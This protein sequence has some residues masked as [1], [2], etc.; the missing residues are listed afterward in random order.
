MYKLKSGNTSILDL[1]FN[2]YSAPFGSFN[3][4]DAPLTE[5]TKD[6]LA[7]YN[8]SFDKEQ[9]WRKI[10]YWPIWMN[11]G[12]GTPLNCSP[13]S[14]GDCGNTYVC[15]GGVNKNKTCSP[16]AY[17]GPMAVPVSTEYPQECRE[18][19]TSACETTSV[20]INPGLKQGTICSTDQ[21]CNSENVVLT[22]I[23]CKKEQSCIPF[24]NDN[25][26]DGESGFN[27][28][29]LP[30]VRNSN[31]IDYVNSVTDQSGEYWATY[32]WMGQSIEKF[33]G[34]IGVPFYMDAFCGSAMFDPTY[35]NYLTDKKFCRF[36]DNGFYQFLGWEPL[37]CNQVS[38]C[39][40]YIN[41]PGDGKCAVGS[42]KKC[43]GGPNAGKDCSAGGNDFCTTAAKGTSFCKSGSLED[44]KNF[45]PYKCTNLN[46]IRG[47]CVGG[48]NHGN[49]CSSANDCPSKTYQSNIG[50]QTVEKGVCVGNPL[51]TGTVL[52]KTSYISNDSAGNRRLSELFVKSFGDWIWQIDRY[53]LTN[54]AVEKDLAKGS[55]V[56]GFA[57]TPKP[58]RIWAVIHDKTDTTK[59]SASFLN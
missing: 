8:S 57:I 42:A 31:C 17:Q 35:S 53:V 38:D 39:I 16:W 6:Y 27:R 2:Q 4:G 56:A 34:G 47:M 55:S 32:F 41:N 36:N 40:S 19:F 5:T 46:Q 33:N 59:V 50:E 11:I 1:P 54:T 14:N 18:E 10:G 48:I 30:C 25:N 37:S 21:D 3:R 45:V 49:P 44:C 9:A 13:N 7:K 12:S 23:T 28:T 51:D 15:D 22:N 52:Q 43:V 58:P 29:D 24:N 26:G 20:C